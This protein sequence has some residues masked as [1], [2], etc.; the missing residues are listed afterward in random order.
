MS[1]EINGTLL[2]VQG[3]LKDG[4]STLPV[5]VVAEAVGVTPGWCP[6]N[7]AVTV[8]GKQLTVT[9][10]AGAS[11]AAARELAAALCLQVEWDGSTNTVILRG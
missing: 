8:N 7:K 6:D 11:Y 2:P 3:Y 1:V 10:E 5:R 4:V 9:I